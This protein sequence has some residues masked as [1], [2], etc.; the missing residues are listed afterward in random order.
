MNYFW[1][2]CAGCGC[3]V[4]V[5][6]ADAPRGL[7]G[8]LRRWSTDRSVNDGRKMEIARGDVDADG[9]F[10]TACVCGAPVP[11]AASAIEHATTET[12]V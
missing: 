3:Q 2:T 1:G 11:I 8:S 6:F 5:Q 4:T 12:P 9:G 10:R 7:T